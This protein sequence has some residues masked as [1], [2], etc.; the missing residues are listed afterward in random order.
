MCFHCTLPSSWSR[1]RSRGFPRRSTAGHA[2][3]TAAASC[4]SAAADST[5][6][7]AS[8]TTVAASST[9]A[10]AADCRSFS[11]RSLLR[12]GIYSCCSFTF[13]RSDRRRRVAGAIL[14]EKCLAV[15]LLPQLRSRLRPARLTDFVG[16]IRSDRQDQRHHDAHENHGCQ[17][18]DPIKSHFYDPLI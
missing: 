13:H 12:G 17:D 3:A 1:R 14:L 9:T 16:E 6:C 2:A 7:A 15:P 4:T 11:S 18:V 10:E 5:T 8:S